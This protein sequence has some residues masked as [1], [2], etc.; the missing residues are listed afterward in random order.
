MPADSRDYGI[1]AQILVDLGIKTMRLLTNN[2]AKRAG[3]EGYG[4]SIVER[5]QIEISPTD[6]NIDYLRTKRDKMDHDI[7]AEK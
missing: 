5:V 3:L 2:P 6:T 1:G 7:K 4:L